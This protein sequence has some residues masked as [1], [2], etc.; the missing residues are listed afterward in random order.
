[1]FGPE[2][3]YYAFD[4]FTYTSSKSVSEFLLRKTNCN[5]IFTNFLSKNLTWTVSVLLRWINLSQWVH[6]TNRQK[7]QLV[8]SELHEFCTFTKKKKKKTGYVV[9]I[10]N[11]IINTANTHCV[12]FSGHLFLIYLL[13]VASALTVN[14]D[15]SFSCK[16]QNI[17][18]FLI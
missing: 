2:K 10:L 14:R 3:L 11:Y 8:Y 13:L 5:I 4:I 12:F 7:P 1:M 6:Y 9:W 15:F 17:P 18:F 16:S